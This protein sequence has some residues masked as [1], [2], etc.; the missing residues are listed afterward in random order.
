MTERVRPAVVG[1][2]LGNSFGSGVVISE[3]GYI[4][5]AGHVIKEPDKDV[6]ILF[7]DG[8]KAQ[9]KSL[10]CCKWADTGMVKITDPGPWKYTDMAA[11]EEMKKGQWCLAAGHPLGYQSTR[12][13]VFRLGR[14][15]QLQPH[16]LQTDATIVAG[17]SGGPLFDLEG[18]VI[19][20]NSR[21]LESIQT[22]F[23]VSIAI[24]HK[25][26]DRMKNGEV[27][28]G[29]APGK[30]SLDFLE[31]FEET[32]EKAGRC[33]VSVKCDDRE[34]ALGTI[35]GPDGWILTKAS[36]LDETITC[37]LKNGTSA[38]ATVVGIDPEFDLAMLKVEASQLPK[39]PWKRTCWNEP[40]GLPKV[41]TVV[42]CPRPDKSVP[43]VIGIVS[44]P[45]HDVPPIDGMIGV[46]VAD[47]E[48]GDGAII[49]NVLPDSPA[50]EAG[51]K[52]NDVITHVNGVHRQDHALLIEEV[53]KHRSG[54]EI[55]LTILRGR[56]SLVIPL[57][58]QRMR[59]AKSKKR[60]M[61]NETGV[62]IST[63]RDG[64]PAVLQHDAALPPNKCGGPLVTL[65]G[66][67]VGIN[68]ARGGRVETYAIPSHVLLTRMYDL[69]S[70]NRKPLA[71]SELSPI[72]KPASK[73]N[74]QPNPE[75]AP[76]TET[77]ENNRMNADEDE[78][79]DEK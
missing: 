75:A 8:E 64:F 65:D 27:W 57:K 67:V 63:R 35:V 14:I 7:H 15:L 70:G 19:G 29:N 71:E 69:M 62:G 55:Q 61:Q 54:E 25:Y 28:G 18:N 68:I 59:T 50:E 26:F 20:I 23:H 30:D 1:L 24:Y 72:K 45:M 60:E 34:V 53:K 78:K 4:L 51:L 40:P 37:D 44:V 73:A 22:N 9:G 36:E 76:K 58:L 2:R 38:A 77:P 47:H 52:V 48:E 41:G 42:A 17:D 79:T 74:D 66:Q 13:P 16:I 21:I 6:E 32:V 11:V 5:T 12:P 56:Q 31:T 39:T 33:V 43:L 3:D 46:I 49:R 10:G